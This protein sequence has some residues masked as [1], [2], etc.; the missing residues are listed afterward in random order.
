MRQLFV[1]LLCGLLSTASLAF[2]QDAKR[3]L[4]LGNSYTYFH[5]LPEIVARIAESQGK[6]LTYRMHA[7]GGWNLQQHWND[8]TA[9]GLLFAERFDAILIQGQSLSPVLFR[10]GLLHFGQL[11]ANEATMAGVAVCFYE[12]MTYRDPTE[13][14]GDLAPYRE[15]FTGMRE[16]VRSAY[17][18]LAARTGG[19]VCPV[20]TAWHLVRQQVPILPLHEPDG[21]HPSPLGAYLSAVV[22]YATLFDEIPEQ[23]PAAIRLPAA[24]V[25]AE[26]STL[27][28]PA[29][30]RALFLDA[31][32]SA[33][34]AWKMEEKTDA[35]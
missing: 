19:T 23:L 8:G 14:S 34:A 24:D 28:V 10:D 5:Q 29:N 11:L 17:A 3:V 27:R 9:G 26:E 31:T 22:I 13:V 33:L 12:T 2:A 7:P 4:F 32:R 16:K 21:S 15:Q 20:G 18:E 25:A 1:V 6:R 35:R 30:L